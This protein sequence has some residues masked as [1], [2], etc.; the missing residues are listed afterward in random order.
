MQWN[1]K[2]FLLI[3]KHFDNVY[4][5]DTG[6]NSKGISTIKKCIKIAII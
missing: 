6:I 4:G 1:N 3:S 5:K 2:Y